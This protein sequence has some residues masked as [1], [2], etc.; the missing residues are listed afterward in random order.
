Q[1]RRKLKVEWDLDQNPHA[2]YDSQAFRRELEASTSKPGKTL[3]NRGDVETAFGLS[4]K[5]VEADYYIPHLA[6]APMEPPVAVA[7]FD[8]GRMEIWSS[9]QGPEVTQHSV[10][11]ALMEPTPANRLRALTWQVADPSE[12]KECEREIQRDFNE[13]LGRQLGVDQATLFKM[14][15][16]LKKEIR[17]KVKV[18]VKLLGGGF[19]RKS[20]PDYAIEA[21]L[22]AK[23]Y[24]GVPIR[25]QWTREDDIQLSYF[26]AVSHQHLE[27]SLGA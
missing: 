17:D 4:P 8:N 10:G 3:R 21:A 23:Q 12:L 16:E 25:V 26:H 5:I 24:P 11:V 27:A 6:Q 18:H 22:L 20:K 13:E 19:G 1:G 14:R 9:T 2:S 7:L 15:D